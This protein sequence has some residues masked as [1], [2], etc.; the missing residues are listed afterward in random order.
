MPIS[1][2]SKPPHRL[3]LCKA[4][5]ADQHGCYPMAPGPGLGLPIFGTLVMRKVAPEQDLLVRAVL[6][7]MAELLAVET[8]RFP[9]TKLPSGSSPLLVG[10]TEP[11]RKTA[12]K[13]RLLV[14]PS[15]GSTQ[16]SNDLLGPSIPEISRGYPF[17]EHSPNDTR[18]SPTASNFNALV[19]A[20]G[21]KR[22][23][24]PMRPKN[25]M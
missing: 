18:R 20:P 2:T 16:T 12:S 21:A 6:R 22:H 9:V 23:E 1:G 5:G 13:C 25:Q 4:E 7:V 10:S 24:V 17:P 3:R 19:S 11:W 15:C 14:P 8:L